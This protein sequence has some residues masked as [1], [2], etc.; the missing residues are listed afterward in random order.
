MCEAIERQFQ[1][2]RGKTIRILAMVRGDI[3]STMASPRPNSKK[4][5][6]PKL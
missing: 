6:M 1:L 3:E 5:I 4:I 2:S